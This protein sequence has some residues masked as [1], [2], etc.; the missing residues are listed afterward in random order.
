[1]TEAVA[2]ATVMALSARVVTAMTRAVAPAVAAVVRMSTAQSALAER[3]LRGHC[4]RQ[5]ECQTRPAAFP[6]RA[7]RVAGVLQPVKQPSKRSKGSC[8]SMRHFSSHLCLPQ[9]HS[10]PQCLM[11]FP[12]LRRLSLVVH[13]FPPCK[14][15][16][17][18]RGK[19]W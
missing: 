3:L 19:Q 8:A 15:S 11:W 18:N 17:Q 5:R 16:S 9:A 4:H 12:L 2:V 7:D 10:R 13:M 1:M 6:V 14:L